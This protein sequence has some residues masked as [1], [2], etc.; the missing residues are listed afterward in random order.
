VLGARTCSIN[1]AI[2]GTR[3][4]PGGVPAM[5]FLR[6]V[7][8]SAQI[9][10]I[11]GFLNSG[12]VTGQQRYLTGCAGCHGADARGGRSGENVRG[13]SADDIE[14]SID[15]DRAMRFLGCLP[16]SDVESIGRYLRGVTGGDGD[17]DD[18]EHDDEHDD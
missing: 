4:F 5:Q 6:G 12:T 11:S 10:A 2:N 15:D 18:D 13:A 9:Q 17:H 1:A 3:V 8:S 7:L 16:S 14:D